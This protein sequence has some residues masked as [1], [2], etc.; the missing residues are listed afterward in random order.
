MLAACIFAGTLGLVQLDVMA[1]T[2]C[3]ERSKFEPDDIKGQMQ[4]SC[5]SIRFGGGL[6]GAVLGATVCNKEQWGIIPSS[7]LLNHFF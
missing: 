4:A 5:Y 3:V 7:I 2:L 6:L 1:D